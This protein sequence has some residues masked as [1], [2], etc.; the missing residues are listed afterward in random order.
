MFGV[1]LSSLA[2]K[3]LTVMVALIVIHFMG[4]MY[5]RTDKIESQ[6]AYDLI[7]ANAVAAADYYGKR[8]I[9]FAIVV[10]LVLS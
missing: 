6:K 2:M 4:W 7:E 9:A 5:D 10:G 3:F 1:G 8:I